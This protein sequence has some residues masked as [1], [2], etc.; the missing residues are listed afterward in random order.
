MAQVSLI[1]GEDRVVTITL[2]ESKTSVAFDLTGATQITFSLPHFTTG[3]SP[4]VSFS[5]TASEITVVDAARGKIQVTMS[6]A[7]TAT[8]KAGVQTAEIVIDKG[9]DRRISQIK[10]AVEVIKKLY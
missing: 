4:A 3:A 2:V 10:E 8:F 1:Q 9:T 7:K 6:D 5:L